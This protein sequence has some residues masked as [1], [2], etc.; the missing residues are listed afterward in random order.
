MHKHQESAMTSYEQRSNWQRTEVA[1]SNGGLAQFIR[2]RRHEILGAWEHEVRKLPVASTLDRPA[3]IDHIP[4]VLDRVAEM[5]DGLAQGTVLT[6][7]KELAEI[8]AVERLEEGFD[9]SQVV[10]EFAILRDCVILL[11]EESVWDPIHLMELRAVNQA[12]DK[13]V[14]ASVGRFT[15]ARDRT[16]LALDRIATEALESRSLDELLQRLLK[17]FVQTTPSVD[18]AAI[19]IREGDTLRVRAALGLEEEIHQGFT[20]QVGEG[21]AGRIAAERRPLGITDASTDPLVKSDILRA[22]G[23]RALYG[24]PLVDGGDTIGV[25]HMGSL[26]AHEFSIQDKRLLGAMAARA[27]AAIFQHML[28]ERAE[29][30]AAELAAIVN[31]Q[32]FL[33]KAGSLLASSLDM[34]ETLRHLAEL[35]VPDLADWCVIDV[36]DGDKLQRVGI[37]HRD[38]EKAKLAREWSERYPPSVDQPY[39]IAE[40]L[41]TGN[42]MFFPTVANEDIERANRRPDYL[43]MLRELGIRSCIIA[44]LSAR[45]RTLGTISL[46]HAE[47]SRHYGPAELDTAAELGRRAGMALDNARLYGAAQDAIHAREEMLAIVS[48][49]LRNPLGSIDLG[50]T[51]ALQHGDAG[52]KTR[53]QLEVIQRSAARMER[54]LR[55]LL[56]TASL[57]VGR[58]TLDMRPV[59]AS[60]IVTDVVDA[61]EEQAKRKSI[62]IER[63]CDIEG[64]SICGDRDRLMQA[65]G[66]LMSN[67]IKFCRAGDRVVVRGRVDG[68][69]LRFEIEDTGPGIP[70]RDLPHI[71]EPYWSAKRHAH[72]GTGLGLYI[73]KGIVEEH[74]GSI[75]VTSVV[76]QGT[77]FTIKLPL[78]TS[79]R[80]C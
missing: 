59:E 39:G 50:A 68:A 10:T 20:L 18:T 6:L 34:A 45:G 55:D 67:S 46:I 28:R 54:L 53:K 78:A 17:V 15:R 1:S 24:V 73:C 74:G 80:A 79:P 22:R 61:Q 4:D 2:D 47:S 3:L 49:D 29:C 65:F 52:P 62:T 14:S 37:A 42:P 69:H 51:M 19:L 32:R 43:R 58:F 35:A 12:I 25:A 8:H 31:D 27:S 75:D 71:F 5:A 36:L 9:L 76:E 11:W 70:E 41:R 66:N 23:V 44:P 57:Q 38:P 13:A 63:D 16:L 72:K 40:V 7:P 33:A 26:T 48:H 60:S 77:T 30:A 64:A 56:D 21:F